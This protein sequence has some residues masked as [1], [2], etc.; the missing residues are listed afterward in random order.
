MFSQNV[1]WYLFLA[2]AGSGTVFAV[3][4]VDSAV[5]RWRSQVF[6]RCQHLIAPGLIAGMTLVAA[7]SIFLV[8]D[9]SRPDRLLNLLLHPALTPL[10]VG[11]WSLVLLMLATTTQLVVRLR[12]A[13][14]TPRALMVMLRWLTA[15]CA[16]VVMLYTGVL[17][18]G[19]SAVAFWVSPLLPLLFVLS[20]LSSGFAVV[21]LLGLFVPDAA[22][23]A[24]GAGIGAPTTAATA[25]AAQRTL[26]HLHA[27]LLVAEALVLALY[28]VVMAGGAQTA[29]QAVV[30]L[31]TGT[32]AQ[33]FWP[34]VVL[35]G[36]LLPF[37]LECIP[38]HKVSMGLVLLGNAALLVG[39]FALR[40][41]LLEVGAHRE[42]ILFL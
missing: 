36:L 23:F 13:A 18:Q 30:S 21:L 39:A 24:G 7:G 6:A 35:G 15:L 31:T 8:F 42:L 34:L 3:F 41:C 16:F 29:A 10:T 27:P 5:R 14:H 20:S 2:G 11:A 1:V 38:K 40:F 25:D 17:L 9:S 22:G 12:L 19:L 28:L 33:F 32:Q 26:S 4:F 37:I